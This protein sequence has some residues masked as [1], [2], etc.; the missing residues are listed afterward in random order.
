MLFCVTEISRP[1]FYVSVLSV[2]LYVKWARE[3]ALSLKTLKQ[4]IVQAKVDAKFL[5]ASL[6]S[7]IKTD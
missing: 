1:F 6:I 4:S 5:F 7:T 3:I 2:V